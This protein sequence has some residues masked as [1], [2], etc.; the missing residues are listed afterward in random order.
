MNAQNSRGSL[1]RQ[2]LLCV[3]SFSLWFAGTSPI[4]IR[5]S[6]SRL[7]RDV[8]VLIDGRTVCTTLLAGTDWELQNVLLEAVGRVEIIR[9]AGDPRPLV[10]IKRNLYGQITWRG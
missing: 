9:G 8:P 7:T 10:G 1:M 5:G 6:D 4:G 2:A 3:M